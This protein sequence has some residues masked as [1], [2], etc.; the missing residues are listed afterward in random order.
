MT[1]I[2]FTLCML[3]IAGIGLFSATKK[4]TNADDYLLASRSISPWLTALSGV[5]TNNSGFMFLG[6]VGISVQE[7]VSAVWIMF[8]WVVGDWL[9]WFVVHGPLR[10][11]SEEV[12]ANTIPGFLSHGLRNGRFVS[13]IAGI[14]VVVFLGLYAAA[15]LKAGSKAL[16]FVF[17]WDLAVGAIIGAVLVAAYCF[18]GGIRASIWTDAAQS[19]VMMGAILLLVFVGIAKIGGLE[20]LWQNLQ[21]QNPRLT[22][23][24][25][26]DYKYGFLGYFL[27]WMGAGAG[28]VGQPHIMVRAMAIDDPANLVKARRIYV[29]WYLLFSAACIAVGLI[30]RGLYPAIFSIESAG[31][32]FIDKE[33][34]LPFLSDKLL[35]GVLVGLT[36]AG[37]LAATISTADSQILSCSAAFTRDIG[38]A[39]N[40]SY[41]AM[42]IATMLVTGLALVFALL[43]GD[44][45][46]GLVVFSWSALAAGLGPLMVIRA[47]QWPVT[48]TSAVL[49]MLGGLGGS[50]TWYLYG[51][52][53]AIAEVL[54]GLLSGF[55]VY[56]LC[57]P[58]QSV[59][60]RPEILASR[61][62]DNDSPENE[63]Q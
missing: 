9:A 16:H 19:V 5:A 55:L 12:G 52:K 18:A 25:P 27:G 2:S 44:S 11:K 61:S 41:K 29:T 47:R 22:N 56:A 28:V 57:I 54:P 59:K 62:Q 37:I 3:V 26:N 38:P 14:I 46:F 58:F 50:L 33:L 39:K 8:G 30:A 63:V 7:G 13:S 43:G 40:R 23:W 21:E 32:N 31:A 48:A 6:L 45:V 42:K 34:A 4:Q 20:A 1:A 24:A 53:A 49:V 60:E 35:P 36:L 17:G 15:Q 51:E 10:K